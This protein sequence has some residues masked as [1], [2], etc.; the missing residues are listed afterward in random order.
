MSVARG[1][2]LGPYQ[3]VSVLGGG[4]TGEVDRARGTRFGRE[5][6]IQRIYERF[7]E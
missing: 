5:V 2:R 7:S 6:A 3:I 1:V 4:G